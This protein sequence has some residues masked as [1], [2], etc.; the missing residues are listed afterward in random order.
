MSLP[1]S[2]SGDGPLFCTS[3]P[4]PPLSVITLPVIP[5]ALTPKLYNCSPFPKLPLIVL[6]TTPT[7][8][9][10]SVN[11]HCRCSAPRCSILPT[12]RSSTGSLPTH[13][14][15]TPCRRSIAGQNHSHSHRHRGYWPPHNSSALLRR[16][17]RKSPHS[18]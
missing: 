4:T 17:A 16:I 7:V 10:C 8:T 3:T 15:A 13:C 18:H 14:C 6:L 9:F 1:E 2:V 11:P 12:T 5:D